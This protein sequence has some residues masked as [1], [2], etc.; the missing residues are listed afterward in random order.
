MTTADPAPTPPAAADRIYVGYLPATPRARRVATIA[1]GAV[2]AG[3]AALGGVIAAAQRPAG[4]AVWDEQ[5]QTWDGYVLEKPYPMLIGGTQ[6]A[7]TVY[8]LV[9]VGKIGA[10]DPLKGL[11]GKPARVSGTLISRSGQGIIELHDGDSVTPLAYD[12]GSDLPFSSHVASAGPESRAGEIVDFKCFL[13]AMKPGDGKGHKACATLC[14]LGG[15][16]PAIV[17]PTQGGGFEWAVLVG[18]EGAA[19]PQ[20]VIPYIA[21][22]VRVFGERWDVRVLDRP[23][24]A[25]LAIDRIERIGG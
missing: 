7:P 1:I 17:T 12:P 5:P 22:P 24:M 19:D 4:P 10:Q 14:I 16:P 13:G 9:G 21:E 11:G 2:V 6:Q 3:A 15:I 20:G 8:L 23:V 25:I 18:T